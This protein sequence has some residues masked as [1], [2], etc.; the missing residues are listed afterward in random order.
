MKPFSLASGRCR[1]LAVLLLAVV[2]AVLPA[3]ADEPPAP[4]AEQVHD[5]Q[6]KFQ[7]ER[8]TA[9]SSG[10]AAK[11]GPD[12]LRRS[13]QLAKKGAA[14]L[15]AGRFAEAADAFREARWQ[16]P[17][18]PADFPDHVVRVLGSNR[19]R[20]G[21]SVEDLSYNGDGSRL[22]TVSRDGIVKIWDVATGRELR[23]I[24]ELAGR[25]VAVL[26]AREQA[27]HSVAVAF[28]PDGKAVA[29][30]AGKDIKLYDP[31]SGKELRTLAGHTGGVTSLAFSA[32]GKQLASGSLD[33]TVRTWDPAE[34]KQTHLLRGHT[35]RVSG[36][37]FSP[38][39]KLVASIGVSNEGKG[40][41]YIWAHTADDKVLI[42]KEYYAQGAG[43]GIA[44]APDGQAFAH[45]GINGLPRICV[46]P[47]AEGK[48]PANAG[49]A[50]LTLGEKPNNTSCLAFSKDGRL[51]ATGGRDH[52]VR[53]WDAATLQPVRVFHGHIAEVQAVAFHPNG[54]QVSSV[55]S[56]QTV[57]LWQLDAETPPQ[58]L[59]GHQ[60]YIWSAA[61]NPDGHRIVSG[62][63]DRSVKI[64]DV[65]TQ[66]VIRSLPAHKAPVTVALFS[67]DGKA[68][69][70]AGGDDVLKLWNADS[71][72]ELR[73]F[74]GHKAAVMAA[75]F[76]KD[77]KRIASAAADRMIKIWDAASA[78]VLHTLEGHQAA[79][80]AVAWHPGGKLLASGDAEGTIKLWNADSGK[81]G[82]T[83]TGHSTGVSGLSFSPDGERLASSGGE[84]LVK[85]W[86]L[87]GDKEPALL[88][89]LDGHT[90]ALSTVTYSADGRLLASAGNDR[91][92]KIWDAQTGNE[93]RTYRGHTDYVSAV[94]FSPDG[95]LL[96]SASVDKTLRLWENSGREVGT[97][98][99]GHAWGINTVV[100]SPDGKTLATGSDDQT[101]RLWDVMTGTE[102]YVL[103]GH[104]KM[105]TAL[106]FSPD[107]KT[108]VSG[109]TDLS[110]RAWDVAS[111]KAVKTLENVGPLPAL[112]FSGDSKQL[113]AW[114]PLRPAQPQ[115]LVR[116]FDTTA[117]TAKDILGDPDAKVRCLAF[118]N[119]GELTAVGTIEGNFR[120]WQTA[121]GERY[122]AGDVLA[123][124][125]EKGLA[126]LIFSADRKFVVTGS[127]DGD[128]RIWDVE[129]LKE[130]AAKEAL[131]SFKAHDGAVRGFA[132]SP[133]GRSFVTIGD[134][135]LKLW[136]LATGKERG[137]WDL[138]GPVRSVAFAPDGKHIAT[139]NGDTTV[140][141]LDVP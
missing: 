42:G 93:L 32:D 53:I 106:A 98:T 108:L 135:K 17:S 64:W 46:A 1:R 18:V 9:V 140:Y 38:D 110:L 74:S 101:I 23:S 34:G 60:G 67:P 75:A 49:N 124:P 6:A 123:F 10:L 12:S 141:I 25:A 14:A 2:A 35:R 50:L 63:A 84:G 45:C 8:E 52:A 134:D 15:T 121:K 4:T 118:S 107:G 122:T 78:K 132:V 70:S 11:F 138:R 36:V 92:V 28:Q 66:K 125:K 5:L 26:Q 85:I 40:F 31:D 27:A 37:T 29:F 90:G 95:H 77:G 88:R 128:V 115:T 16:L 129:K 3:L 55:S 111:G 94:A 59:A 30:A 114:L 91:L 39:G 7:S 126:D 86:N 119:D 62:S 69:L 58:Q 68:I 51:L 56:D 81:V 82:V 48:L 100:Y 65:A 109:S 22:A 105:L 112:G 96:L 71:G 57:R 73:T 133:D 33:Q 41:V 24:R 103:L 19:L 20:H 89:K 54:R 117:W 131:H 99:V 120:I 79:V 80:S 136:E 44:F 61:F 104:K 72:E 13:D 76:D 113:F 97:T 83:Y 139:A 137:N 127:L 47:P 116:S 130:G 102:K 21:D 87:A 43:L